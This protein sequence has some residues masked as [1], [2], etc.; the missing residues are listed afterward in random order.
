MNKKEII[1][2]LENEVKVLE[3]RLGSAKLALRAFGQVGEEPGSTVTATR[4]RVYISPEMREKYMSEVVA[5]LEAFGT[6][7]VKQLAERGNFEDLS[8]TS[9]Y[10]LALSHPRVDRYTRG[11][12]IFFRLHN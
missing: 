2:E 12:T 11:R 10:R 9:V 1:T 6:C 3:E 7:T 4:K 5:V 8:T